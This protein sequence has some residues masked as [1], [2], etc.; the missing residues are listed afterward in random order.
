MSIKKDTSKLD[1]LD[2]LVKKME[3]QT[4]EW[5]FLSGR[6][7]YADGVSVAKVAAILEADDGFFTRAIEALVGG[8]GKKEYESVLRDILE[9]K[10][11]PEQASKTLSQMA[12]KE[13]VKM[14]DSDD[15]KDTGT[16]RKTV[17]WRVKYQG[18]KTASGRGDRQL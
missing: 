10:I 17:R 6:P 18:K 2:Q 15:K 7:K 8:P 16:L 9:D 11:T 3:N 13:L 5:G 12:A 4:G 1:E 14:I